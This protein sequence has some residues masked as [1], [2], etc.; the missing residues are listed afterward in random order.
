MYTLI[1]C[2]SS[3]LTSYYRYKCVEQI[4]TIAAMLS[5]GNAVFYRPK[6]KLT[7]A[8]KANN[9][10]T[11][12]FTPRGDH[13]TLLNVYSQVRI[14]T[15]EEFCKWQFLILKIAVKFC[16]CERYRYD[17]VVTLHSFLQR[18]AFPYPVTR[19]QLGSIKIETDPV[20]VIVMQ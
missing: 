18:Y 15:V 11:N 5:V 4:L 13:L 8:D 17:A 20:S 1:Y 9:F 14:L 16:M 12:F 3:T 10:F 6:D 7:D 19:F 2:K